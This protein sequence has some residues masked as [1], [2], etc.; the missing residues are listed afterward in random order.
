MIVMPEVS[1]I[2]PA[3]RATAYIAEALDSVFAQTFRDFEV[4][5]VNDGCPDTDALER[6]LEPYRSCIVYVKI[7][8]N[9][10]LAGARNA[11]IRAAISP[12][13]ALLDADD[14]WEPDYL[15][16][17]L[18][19]LKADPTI[20]IV[21]SDARMFGNPDV[22]GRRCMELNPSRGEV[23]FESLMSLQCNVL[24]SVTGKREIFFKAGLFEE[25]RRRVEDFDLWLRVVK[26]GGRIVYHRG[27]LVRLRRRSDSL[28]AGEE[29]MLVARI[30]VADKARRT[31][32]LTEAECTAADRQIRLCQARLNVVRGKQALDAG[33][34]EDAAR[35]FQDAYAHFRTRKLAVIAFMT[36]IAPRLLSWVNQRRAV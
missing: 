16:I 25:G 4:V 11:G 27:V 35:H 9:I 21:Y 20:D 26:A 18:G 30:E 22:E 5:V 12:C 24:V 23:T 15:E 28:S 34:M 33:R 19:M 8:T 29:P 13:L 17:Q 14:V 7:E 2:I 3:Y 36:R 10:G 1:I 31:L 32:H 6:V